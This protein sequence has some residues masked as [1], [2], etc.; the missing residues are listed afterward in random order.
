MFLIFVMPFH[1]SLKIRE[2]GEIFF[3]HVTFV[4]LNAFVDHNM[5]LKILFHSKSFLTFFTLKGSL[6]CVNAIV[7]FEV[8]RQ[9]ES[10][11]TLWTFISLLLRVN[12]FMLFKVLTHNNFFAYFTFN[13]GFDF[14]RKSIPF[15][16]QVLVN[17]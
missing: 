15:N 9:L 13:F 16:F 2:L 14:Q 6:S 17:V 10:F 8:M 11:L 3:T 12:P 7:P 1:V 4:G 5:S